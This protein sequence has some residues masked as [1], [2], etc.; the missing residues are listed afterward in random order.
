M[1]GIQIY[2]PLELKQAN[3]PVLKRGSAMQNAMEFLGDRWLRC[4][5]HSADKISNATDKKSNAKEKS[6]WATT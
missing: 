4:H 2:K 5:Q 1:N 6:A 3:P